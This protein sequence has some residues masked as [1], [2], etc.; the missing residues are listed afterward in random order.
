MLKIVRPVSFLLLSTALCSSGTM[1]AANETATPKVGI[2]QQQASLKGIVEDEFG[3]VAGASVVVKGTT[4]GTVTDMDGNFVLDVKK[5]DVIVISFIGYLTQEIKYNGE[6]SIKVNLKEDTQKLDEVVVVGYGVQKKVNLTGSVSTVKAETLETRPVSSV[7]AALAGQMPGVTA[8]QSSGRP[9]SQTGSITIRGKN[10]VNAA[11]PLVIVDGVPGSMNTI[12]PADIESLTVLKDASSAAIYGV[13]A[14]NGVILITTKKGKKGDRARVNYSGNV[15]WSTPTMRPK[16]LGSAD[17]AMLYNEATLNDN[18]NNP[19]RFTDEDIELYRNGTDPYGHPNTDWYK[20]AL[21]KNA[22]ETMHHISISG[23]SEKT[24]YSASVGYTQQNGLID[25]NN[26]KRFNARTSVDSQ[27]NKW[28]SAGLNV[29]GYRGTLMDGWNSVASITQFT[30]R[31]TPV[32]AVRNEEGDFLYHG[33]DNPLAMLGRDGFR[34]T[35]DQQ[36]NGTL[37]GQVNIL[38]NLTAKALFSIRNDERSEDGFKTQIT[39]GANNEATTGLREGYEKQTWWNWYTTQ[40]LINYNETW[41]KH[42]LGLLAGF[43]QIDYRYKHLEAERKGGGNNEL[44]ESLSTLDASSQT[45]KESRYEIAH[46]S[47]FGR[48]QYSFA[49]K[50]L[51]EANVRLDGSSRFAS[52]NRW[53]AFPAFSAGWRITEEEF[54]KNASIDWLSN[55]KLRAGWG[56]TGNEELKDGEAY[57]TV[58][59]YAYESYMF[60]NSLYSTAYESR[61]ANKDLKWATVTSIEGAIEAS[62]LN[63]KIGFELAGYKKTTNDMLLLLPVQG[64]LGLDAPR[65]NAGQVQNTGFDLSIF[66]NNSISKDFRY[67]INFNIAYVHNELTDLQGTEGKEPDDGRDNFWFLEGYPIGSYYGYEADGLFNS[68]E[69]VAAGPTRTGT[70]QPGDIRYKDLNGDGKIDAANDK[71]VI[72]KEFPSWTAGLGANLYYKDFDLSFFFQGAFDVDAYV[73]GEAAYAFFNGGKVLER[74]LDRWTPTNHNA[75][76][77]RITKD[78]QINYQFSSYW[79]QDA[80]YVRLKNLTIG[81]NIPKALLSKIN[82]DRVKVFLTGENLFTITGMDSLDPESAPSNPRGGLYSNVRKISIGLKVGF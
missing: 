28:F 44:Q 74:H 38:P 67:D 62:F 9:G 59:S 80:S 54:M 25:A 65:Q 34:R 22:I 20:E 19:L 66:H 6:Q 72:G 32:E 30:N 82:L 63:N 40:V 64:V 11:S 14:A 8:I 29:S 75:S 78:D 37:Y 5:G 41:G 79:L 13:Q 73:N 50:Y 1:F 55:L 76:Y 4:N 7:S 39:Y 43:E 27:I 52:G 2:S 53:G 51:L 58:P 68:P 26:Y 46:R 45:N 77:P 17:Y 12:D 48:A 47:Y 56:Q 21:N 16:F 49:D 33:K 60:G 23:G 69:E 61:Y 57:L 70:E 71:K 36:V 35:M 3:P 15:G 81:Y 18:P 42:D 10:S 31:A 24:S